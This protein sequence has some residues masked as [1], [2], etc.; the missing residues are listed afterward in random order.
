[1]ALYLAWGEVFSAWARA[2]LGDRDGGMTGLREA[3]A[4]YL[5]QGNKLYAS[6]FQGLLA[7]LEAEGRDADGPL[8]RI[9]D[10]LALATETGEQWT[11]APLHRIRGQILVKLEP[12]NPAPAEEDFQTAI[13]IAK[14]QG[15]RSYELLASLSLAKLYQS[16]GRPADAHAVLAPTLE[17]FSPTPEMPEIAEAQTLLT[18]LAKMGQVKAHEIER[19]RRLRLHVSYGNALHAARG[20]TKRATSGGGAINEA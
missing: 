6:L 20:G 8:R 16:T 1:M 2:R 5:D 10:A 4:A 14:Q 17:G 12:A 19:Q 13:A 11:G 7:E 15:A 3:L 9:D 18:A